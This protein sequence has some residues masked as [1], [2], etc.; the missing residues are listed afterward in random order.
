[1]HI[2]V[3]VAHA[4]ASHTLHVLLLLTVYTPGLSTTLKTRSPLTLPRH[5][6]PC[7]LP[8]RSHLDTDARLILK[9]V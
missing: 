4:L 3:L 7:P 1:M 5:V 9:L 8:P 2:P 6:F